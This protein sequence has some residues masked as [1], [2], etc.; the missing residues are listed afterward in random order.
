MK[1]AISG[2]NGYIASSLIPALEA[3][4]HTVIRIK[5]DELTDVGKLVPTL[6]NASVVINLA[7]A[8][9]FQ[10]WNSQSKN[11]ILK[12]RVD[13]TG[14][15]TKA[16][17]QLPANQRPQLFVS[18]SAV[19]IYAPNLIHTETSSVFAD[20]FV[21]Q[22]VKSWEK[23]SEDL[24]LKVR[25]VV[26]RIGLI[27][28][29][30]AKTIKNLLPLFKSGLGGKIGSGKQPFP[31]IHIDDVV[32]AI[33]WAINNNTAK[34]IYNLVAPENIDNKIFTHTLAKALRRPALFTVPSFVLKIALSETST[35]LLNNPQV[36][37]ERLLN[38]GFRFS[39]PDIKSCIGQIVQKKV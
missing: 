16:I 39:Y 13:S 3:A 9:I 5:R 27:L 6:T 14:N 17:N 1:I 25:H 11:E 10:R 33:L 29:S 34:G 24:D 20:G 7:G 12:S 19:G 32:N 26:F 18:A 35:L 23:A 21:S 38:E 30:E 37:P 36:Y 2:S 8:P 22:V 28:G 31:F 15:I 4:N